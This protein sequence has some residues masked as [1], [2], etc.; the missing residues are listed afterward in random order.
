MSGYK[1]IRYHSGLDS[2]E[3]V[4]FISKIQHQ[5]FDIELNENDIYPLR[6]IDTYFYCPL[7]NQVNFWV[8]VSNENKIIGTVG[9]KYLNKKE[10]EVKRFFV[11]GDYRGKGV[12]ADLMTCVIEH[13]QNSTIYLGTA[14]NKARAI[15]FYLKKGF[16]EI[17]QSLLPED[18]AIDPLDNRFFKLDTAN[19]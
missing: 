3:I 19:V 6:N 11:D 1:I 17:D 9:L 15:G 12:S 7:T 13:A 10:Y 14:T 8:A 2:D 16:V 5:E 18:Y 4:S